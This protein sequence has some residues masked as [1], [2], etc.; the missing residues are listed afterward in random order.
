MPELAPEQLIS[1]SSGLLILSALRV[2]LFS[3][4]ARSESARLKQGME[5]A[6]RL[7]GRAQDSQR[8]PIVLKALLLRGQ[9]HA[10]AGDEQAGLADVARAIELAELE[11]AISTF[12]EEGLPVAAALAELL[13][14][15]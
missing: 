8:L 6:G 3:A 9:M 4:K 13:E 11:G 12:V 5:L 1:H 14:Q 10:V 2:Q 7:I 15:E